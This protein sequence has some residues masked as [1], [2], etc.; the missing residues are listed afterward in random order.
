MCRPIECPACHKT[1]WAGCGAHVDQV[2]SAV[3]PDARC[4]CS[5]EQRRAAA[6]GESLWSSLRRTL[7]VGR[8]E[9]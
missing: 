4:A 8:R 6:A 2:M 1:T 3:P 7:G 5:A 9:R